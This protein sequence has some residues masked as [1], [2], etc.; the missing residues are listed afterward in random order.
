MIS[1]TVTITNKLYEMLRLLLTP[2]VDYMTSYDV[3]DC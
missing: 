2:F 1:N 3:R